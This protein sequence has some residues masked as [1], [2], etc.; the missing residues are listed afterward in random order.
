MVW[1][2]HSFTPNVSDNVVT[3][4]MISVVTVSKRSNRPPSFCNNNCSGS[5]SGIASEKHRTHG[6]TLII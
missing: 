4:F 6:Y 2:T 3:F 1:S 5:L